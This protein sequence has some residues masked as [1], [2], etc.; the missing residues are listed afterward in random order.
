[1]THPSRISEHRQPSPTVITKTP[2]KKLFAVVLAGSIAVTASCK[3]FL[4][5][6]T[7]PNAP[8]T[9]TANLYLPPMLH[10]WVSAPQWDGR[11]IARYT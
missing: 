1:M 6:N 10:W 5:V 11:F 4:D 7:N 3:D 8:Q 2:M 9:V